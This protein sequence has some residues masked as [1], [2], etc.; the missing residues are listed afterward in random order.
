MNKIFKIMTAIA[1][2]PVL[3]ITFVRIFVS[4][5]KIDFENFLDEEDF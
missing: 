4:N 1:V 5:F 2:L 3:W